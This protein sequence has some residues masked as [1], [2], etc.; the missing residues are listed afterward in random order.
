MRFITTADALLSLCPGADFEMLFD[1]YENLVWHSKEIPIP[2]KQQVE[3]E[4][5]RLKQV[6]ESTQYK[7]QRL[8]DYPALGEQLDMLW[9][10]M[11]VDPAKR[12]EP[13]YSN[14]KIIKEK[15]PKG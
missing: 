13:F 2:T 5:N 8:A 10:A 7:W 11:D 3:N 15:Y 9:H 1:E 4:K 12:L 6:E 14:I